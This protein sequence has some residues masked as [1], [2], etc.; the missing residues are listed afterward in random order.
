MGP[1]WGPPGSCWPQMGPMMAPMN[2]ALWVRD[3][4]IS[5]FHWDPSYRVHPNNQAHSPCFTLL[6]Y[7]L[8]EWKHFKWFNKQYTFSTGCYIQWSVVWITSMLHEYHSSWNNANF[9]FSEKFMVHMLLPTLYSYW[10]V[11]EWHVCRHFKLKTK[12]KGISSWLR[13][14]HL[15]ALL[16]LNGPSNHA[17]Y[18]QSFWKI[19]AC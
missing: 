18:W 15:L 17:R 8:V 2:L 3:E 10:W 9:I 6:W 13:G 12:Q 4:L 1:T 14:H 16:I 7:G 19:S 5:C 11:N